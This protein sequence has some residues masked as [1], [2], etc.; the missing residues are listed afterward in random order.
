MLAA[1]LFVA[2]IVLVAVATAALAGIWWGV[3]VAG[4]ALIVLG[5]LTEMGTLP[6]SP[7]PTAGAEQ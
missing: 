1:F 6:M 3:L 2:G 7:A 4:I 5:V